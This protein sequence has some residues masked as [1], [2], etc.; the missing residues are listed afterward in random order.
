MKIRTIATRLMVAALIAGLFGLLC[1][2]RAIQNSSSAVIR[3]RF[4]IRTQFLM[5]K[6]FRVFPVEEHVKPGDHF[7]YTISARPSSLRHW[8][9]Q[10]HTASEHK[11][12]WENA[13]D[14]YANKRQFKKSRSYQRGSNKRST[15]YKI[16]NGDRCWLILENDEGVGDLNIT[17]LYQ[18]RP[19]NRR[20]RKYMNL[21]TFNARKLWYY[22]SGNSPRYDMM[23]RAS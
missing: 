11:K 2:M 1:A 7:V 10:I 13:F 9:L 23:T 20:I 18:A 3:D 21:L 5:P 16:A 17:F 14:H 6:G 8:R 15:E 12:H 19:A 22:L 4:G